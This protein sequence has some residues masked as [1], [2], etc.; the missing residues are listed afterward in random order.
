MILQTA[1]KK[2]RGRFRRDGSAGR[3][4]S[5]SVNSLVLAGCQGRLP[6][7]GDR[8][9]SVNLQ[10]SAGCSLSVLAAQS[11]RVDPAPAAQMQTDGCE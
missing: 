11:S 10:L 6:Q 9:R 7:L 2:T 3:R 5:W 4:K 1:C 8:K